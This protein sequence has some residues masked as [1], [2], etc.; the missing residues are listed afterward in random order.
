LHTCSWSVTR[1]RPGEKQSAL[2]VPHESDFPANRPRQAR[3]ATTGRPLAYCL[4]SDAWLA[5][6]LTFRA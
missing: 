2:G 6:M 1:N 3:K 5:G 4:G